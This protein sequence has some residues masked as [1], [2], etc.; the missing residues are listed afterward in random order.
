VLI[1]AGGLMKSQMYRDIVLWE[2]GREGAH[3]PVVEII[4]DASIF[5]VESLKTLA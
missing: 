3:F 4:E 1:L 5:G 2:L